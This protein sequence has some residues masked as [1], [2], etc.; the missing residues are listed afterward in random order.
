MMRLCWIH[1]L[2]ESRK[3]FRI[4]VLNY[5]V[6]SNHIHLLVIENSCEGNISRFMQLLQ[7]RTAQEYNLRKNR[8]GAFWED[9][10]H[11]TAIESD[12]HLLQC[13]AYINMNMVR[14]GAVKHPLEWKE[15]GYYEIGF[16]RKRYVIIDYSSLL[17]VLN[18]ESLDQLQKQQSEWVKDSMERIGAI[19]C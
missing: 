2:Y 4:S 18:F 11:A 17:K 6:T 9:R 16:P 7:S 19:A 12:I 14:A 10:Y 8:K 3:R 5:I 15:S 1:W 13:M